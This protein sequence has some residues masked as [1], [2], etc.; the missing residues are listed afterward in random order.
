MMTTNMT[1]TC[2]KFAANE[3]GWKDTVRADGKSVTR[4]IVRF[5]GYPGQYV[6]HCPTREHGVNERMRPYEIVEPWSRAA[7]KG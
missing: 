2:S 4:M 3:A 6:W 7:E 1:T 5:D